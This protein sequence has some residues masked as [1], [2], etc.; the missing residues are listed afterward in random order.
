MLEQVRPLHG[1]LSNTKLGKLLGPQD[2]KQAPYHWL[3]QT[4]TSYL[5]NIWVTSVLC[6]WMYLTALRCSKEEEIITERRKCPEIGEQ[7][8]YGNKGLHSWN[9]LSSTTHPVSYPWLPSQQGHIC[10]NVTQMELARK[11]KQ[12]AI[13]QKRKSNGSFIFPKDIKWWSDT[14]RE[15]SLWSVQEVCFHC[16]LFRCEFSFYQTAVHL[17][18]WTKGSWDWD[19]PGKQG[20]LSRIQTFLVKGGPPKPWMMWLTIL[21]F[22]CGKICTT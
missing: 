5:A 18:H 4:A 17:I 22:S 12:W 13:S 20:D 10:T 15:Q 6:P 9:L 16:V 7:N 21:L 2:I 1:W 14:D 11:L 3:F 19:H 8:F